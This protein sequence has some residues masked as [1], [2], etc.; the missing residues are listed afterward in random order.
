[1]KIW[2]LILDFFSFLQKNEKNFQGVAQ[3]DKF[4]VYL[5][6]FQDS[7]FCKSTQFWTWDELDLSNRMR[8]QQRGIKWT[9]TLLFNSFAL[10]IGFL[11]NF[12]IKIVTMNGPTSFGTFGTFRTFGTFGTSAATP[13]DGIQ[14]ATSSRPLNPFAPPFVD[15]ENSSS[16]GPI[17]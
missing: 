9:N 17:Q 10:L 11:F 7:R 1:M 4:S 16:R 6:D 5:A 15:S 14:A 3:C 2:K 12:D 13:M 8:R